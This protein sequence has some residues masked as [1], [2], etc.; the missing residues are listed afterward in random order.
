MTRPYMINDF[1]MRDYP[2]DAEPDAL[3]TKL[4]RPVKYMNEYGFDVEIVGGAIHP[5][6]NWIAW[7]DYYEKTHKD[8]GTYWECDYFLRIKVDDTQVFEWNVETYNPFF[9]AL[10]CHMDW[11][12]DLL[13]YIYLEKHLLYGVTL[14]TSELITRVELGLVGVE[15]TIVDNIV[16]ILPVLDYEKK[17][18]KRYRIPSWEELSPITEDEAFKLGLISWD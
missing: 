12:G 5:T 13:V 2:T 15:M 3:S 1:I 17:I 18:L 11:Y 8:R 14:T 16:Y 7:V 10:T 6:K 4:N 9:G